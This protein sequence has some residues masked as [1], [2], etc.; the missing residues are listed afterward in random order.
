MHLCLRWSASPIVLFLLYADNVNT[1]LFL[2]I[3]AYK[4]FDHL[5]MVIALFSTWK[6]KGLTLCIPQASWLCYTSYTGGW[7]SKSWFLILSSR[8]VQRILNYISGSYFVSL[9]NIDILCLVLKKPHLWWWIWFPL[10]RD[11]PLEANSVLTDF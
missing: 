9:S 5:I 11:I 2:L 4:L 8:L 6:P 3:N 7:D 1:H 10:R